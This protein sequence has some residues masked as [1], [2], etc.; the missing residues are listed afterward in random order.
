MSSNIILFCLILM[1]VNRYIALETVR[2]SVAVTGSEL[3]LCG[4]WFVVDFSSG[5]RAVVYTQASLTGRPAGSTQAC[6]I[7]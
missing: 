5:R 4:A 3:F 2:L 7:R 6:D 1:R